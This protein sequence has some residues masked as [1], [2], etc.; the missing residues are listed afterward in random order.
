[1]KFCIVLYNIKWKFLYCI[2]YIGLGILFVSAP[3][4]FSIL[5]L[6]A[7]AEDNNLDPESRV[8]VAHQL[9]ST[10]QATQ[11]HIAWINVTSNNFISIPI[12]SFTCLYFCSSVLFNSSPE[13]LSLTFISLLPCHTLF[14]FIPRNSAPSEFELSS[15]SEFDAVLTIATAQHNN[16]WV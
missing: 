10:V 3:A 7:A 14:F 16:E 8:S 15:N 5:L 1:M 6:E 13:S 11:M 2:L 12:C 9:R 4:T